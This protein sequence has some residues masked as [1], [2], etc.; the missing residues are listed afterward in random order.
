V[1]SADDV[2]LSARS[3]DEVTKDAVEEVE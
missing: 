1:R 3:K 2:E